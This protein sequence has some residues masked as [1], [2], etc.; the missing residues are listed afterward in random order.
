MKK[1]TKQEILDKALARILT[2]PG[3]F[4]MDKFKYTITKFAKKLGLYEDMDCGTVCCFAGQIVIA[5]KGMKYFQSLDYVEV[6][7]EAQEIL[8]LDSN[9]RRAL[10][11]TDS[12][13]FEDIR[14]NK[15]EPGTKAYAQ[16]AVSAIKRYFRE[17]KH[18]LKEAA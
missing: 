18:L 3:K 2:Y 11:Y 5:A 7:E 6:S 9:D 10:F 4:T 15:H 12:R 16:A 13:Y 14:I 17:H 1:L 8:G